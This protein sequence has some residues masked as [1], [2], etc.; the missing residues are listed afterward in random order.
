MLQRSSTAIVPSRGDIDADMRS[1]VV[2]NRRPSGSLLAR[3]EAHWRRP[4]HLARIDV[5][6]N[7]RGDLLDRRHAVR[8]LPRWTPVDSDVGPAVRKGQL[9]RHNGQV[10]VTVSTADDREIGAAD[11]TRPVGSS[12]RIV[13][14]FKAASS[15]SDLSVRTAV[16]AEYDKAQGRY[17]I[18][19]VAHASL[20][21]NTEL[22]PRLLARVQLRPIVQRAAPQCVFVTL[23]DETNPRAQWISIDSLT[24]K[25]GRILSPAIAEAVVQR[26]SSPARMEAIELLYGA[27]ALA[28]LPPAQLVQRELGITHR[29]A[30]AWI[31]DARNAGRL[32]GMN[33]NAGR[34]AAV[35]LAAPHSLGPSSDSGIALS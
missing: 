32:V 30:S 22:T 34:Q 14:V 29:T 17:V 16:I 6:R 9:L 4:F 33:F 28:G 18:R 23:D 13:P 11:A 7:P 1:S 24:T 15:D 8:H 5:L 25:K 10:A 31:Q 3:A 21:S 12:L 2:R 27:A 19:Q 26:G 20:D 35:D